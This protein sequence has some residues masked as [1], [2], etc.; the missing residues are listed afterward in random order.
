MLS[1]MSDKI[2]NTKFTI[3]LSQSEP[4]HVKAADILN[5]QKRYGK[6]QYIVDAIM[7]YIGCGLTESAA[8]PATQPDE[9][10]IEK[11]V[12]R[13]LSDKFGNIEARLSTPG[14]QVESTLPSQSQN[15]DKIDFA[16]TMDGIGE[17]GIKAVTDALA[18]FRKK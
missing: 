1:G 9:K 3:R 17:E 15:T 14:R 2:E 5:Q 18:S 11:I 13:I 12:N 6:T 4:S 8:Y 16:E 10:Y 7:H